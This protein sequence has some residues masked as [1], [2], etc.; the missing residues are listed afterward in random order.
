MTKDALPDLVAALRGSQG[1]AALV[2]LLLD[3]G[4]SVGKAKLAQAL[5]AAASRLR[6]R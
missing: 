4:A 3:A 5:E 1:R 2:E 6:G